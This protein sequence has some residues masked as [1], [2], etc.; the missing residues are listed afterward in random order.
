VKRELVEP[1]RPAHAA[2]DGEDHAAHPAAVDAV[3]QR[4]HMARLARPVA[5]DG[6]RDARLRPCA[7]G[8]DQRVV[9]AV[10]AGREPN[11]VNGGG[12]RL[13]AVDAVRGAEVGRDF[14]EVVF[15]RRRVPERLRRGGR[16]VHEPPLRRHDLELDALPRQ[17]AQREHRLH[18]GEAA[19]GDQHAG[20]GGS[21]GRRHAASVARAAPR[22]D[23]GP[24]RNACGELRTGAQA[25]PLSRRPV[26]VR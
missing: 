18:G 5:R 26:A 20:A 21:R 24:P 7:Q 14:G 3:E 23:R 19:A 12:D 8:Q 2:R 25:K 4:A 10:R 6:A 9:G 13:D 15:E 22:H 1:E 17:G 16:P 11:A